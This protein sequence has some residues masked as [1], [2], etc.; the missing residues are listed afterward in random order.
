MLRELPR[1]GHGV[2]Q[3]QQNLKDAHNQL[4]GIRVADNL[5]LKAKFK[6]LGTWKSRNV[7]IQKSG[8]RANPTNKITSIESVLA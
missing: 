1:T 7:E 6:N 4:S 2:A 5:Q 3:C 8:I